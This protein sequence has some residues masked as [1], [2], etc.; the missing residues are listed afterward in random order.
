M[1][2]VYLLLVAIA[3]AFGTQ[4]QTF[5]NA[6]MESWRTNTAGGSAGAPS[7]TIHAPISWY[8]FDSTIIED[9]ELFGGV[10]GA[11]T[12]WH[13]QLFEENTIIH[14]GTASA[15]LMTLKQDTFGYVGSIMSNAQLGLDIAA[16]GGGTGGIDPLSALTFTG[17]TATTLRI[18]TVS[19]W[20]QLTGG[21]DTMTHMM[22]GADTG[23]MAVQA[24][25]TAYGADSVIGTG[26]VQ[27]LRGTS[28]S[29]VTAT[30]AYIDT[31]STCDIIRVIFSSGSSFSISGTSLDST[32]LY[33]D[34]VTMTGIPQVSHVAVNNV[35]TSA[36]LVKVYPNPA[37]NTVY[38]NGPQHAGLSVKI[39]SVTGQV[40]ASQMLNGNDE[41]NIASL[42]SGTYLY[43]ISNAAGK[44]VQHGQISKQ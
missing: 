26:F 5:S 3:A 42:A 40:M 27:I 38:F 14:G 37:T 11:G 36:K 8:G 13:A 35:A 44:A 30:V 24:V 31:Y 41:V 29:E 22:G 39:V 25:C 1:K 34:D 23:M 10:I 21:I 28:F 9:G 32:T 18:M 16:L 19:A 12:D 17:G 20:T 15:K 7:F 33:V 6:G 2:K 43:S 4:A